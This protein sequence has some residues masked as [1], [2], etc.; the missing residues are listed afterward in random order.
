MILHG[1]GRGFDRLRKSA[2]L[3]PLNILKNKKRLDGKV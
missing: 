2:L 1:G 3:S